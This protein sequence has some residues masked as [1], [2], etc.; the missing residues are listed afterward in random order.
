MVRFV[1]ELGNLIT[2]YAE[3]YNDPK[4]FIGVRISITGP[5]SEMTNEITVEEAKHL[6]DVLHGCLDILQNQ[7]QG[8][9]K[10]YHTR[11]YTARQGH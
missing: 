7:Q 2:I 8:H 6:N 10:V 4:G 1:N 5:S 11:S 3:P 9:A